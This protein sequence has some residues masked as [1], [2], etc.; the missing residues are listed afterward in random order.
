MRLALVSLLF[1]AAASVG[2]A[3][4]P[5]QYAADAPSNQVADSLE[6]SDQAEPDFLKVHEAFVF[7]EKILSNGVELSWDIAD[8]YFLYFERFKFKALNEGV[9]I[10]TPEFSQKGKAKNDPYFGEVH[11]I[12]DKLSV[13]LPI[14]LAAGVT[15]GEI[16]VTYQG[17][18]EA[19][20]CYPPTRKTLMYLP[21]SSTNQ[22]SASANTT[23]QTTTSSANTNTGSVETTVTTT[24]TDNLEDA[25]GVFNFIQSS[26][27]PTII[28][29]FF[30]LGLGLTFTPCVFPMIPIITSIIAGQNK[31]T[32]MKSLVLSTTYVLGMAITYAAAG[33]V[34]GMLGAGANVQAALQDPLLLS[35]FASIFVLLALAM[36]GLYELQLP[37]FIRDRLNN[38][39]QNLSGGHIGSVFLIGAL[40]ALVV[41]PCVSAPLAG[42]LLYISATADAVIGG[43]S[44][45]ALGLGMGVPLI[46][47]SVGGGKLF[48][49]AGAWMDAVKG[50]FGVMLLAVAIWL[51]SRFVAAEVIMVL[52]AMLLGLSATQM[53]AFDAA[54]AGWPRIFK[55]LGLMLA[56]YAALLV[57][58]AASG[59]NNPLRPLDAISSNNSTV[60]NIQTKA[61]ALKFEKIY[62]MDGLSQQLNSANIQQRPTMVDFYA[63]WCISCKIMEDQ[64]FP[65]PAIKQ[66]MQQFHL[67]K[68]D[69]TEND[70]GNQQLME[71]FGLF[72]P[73]SILFFDDKGNELKALRIVG[74]V[75]AADFQKRLDAALSGA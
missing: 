52:W 10:G 24:S 55:G 12:H 27:L 57:I 66:R 50:V 4:D 56:L 38:T 26:S 35:I 46:L 9:T 45:F 2:H 33:V 3:F 11:V 60:S 67:V 63:D 7:N 17:C 16:K 28:G 51:L 32:V 8:E 61:G 49:K 18:A 21:V 65:L 14:T 47:I 71:S 48:P 19:G 37:A 39:S 68:A 6:R 34:T 75:T 64:V 5:N 62:A 42:A 54:S 23:N 31:P 73:P 53:G 69:V 43:A 1:T 72:G 40:S 70:A 29:I 20:L 59:S 25:S 15:E 36:F 58:G 13:F 30:L 41:S 44:L 74:E 22:T